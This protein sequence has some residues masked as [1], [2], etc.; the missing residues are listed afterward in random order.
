MRRTMFA[1]T[2]PPSLQPPPH[3]LAVTAEATASHATQIR[4]AL[5]HGRL[6]HLGGLRRDRHGSLHRCR[7]DPHQRPRETPGD[8]A[9][10]PRHDQGQGAL[11][12]SP[13]RRRQPNDVLR[14]RTLSRHA[15]AARRDPRIHKESPARERSPSPPAK[16]S[17]PCTA[18]ARSQA[19]PSSAR[20][21]RS[22]RTCT[23]PCPEINIDPYRIR[24]AMT[25][26]TPTDRNGAPQQACNRSSFLIGS[27]SLSSWSTSRCSLIAEL[28]YQNAKHPGTVSNIAWYAFL[29][30]AASLVILVIL[31]IMPRS[32]R[33]AR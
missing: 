6:E 16:S 30:G 33:H 7:H 19:K 1:A 22:P 9:A 3:I 14:D 12:Q 28:T 5:I 23:Y 31:A 10:L 25:M 15:R 4:D 32:R 27:L 13:T 26:Q 20:N 17:P 11:H 8:D 21:R 2:A 24:K 29:I 18:N